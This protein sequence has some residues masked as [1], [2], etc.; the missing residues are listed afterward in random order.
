M[1]ICLFA[2]QVGYWS[3]FID[4]SFEHGMS[5]KGATYTNTGSLSADTKF[6][7]R[8]QLHSYYWLNIMLSCSL[9]KPY[10]PLSPQHI[11]LHLISSWLSQTNAASQMCEHC[12]G[13]VQW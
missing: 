4:G 6:E 8:T 12:I 5:H 9:D 2:A 1:L 11:E 13:L 10:L 3:L 7:V